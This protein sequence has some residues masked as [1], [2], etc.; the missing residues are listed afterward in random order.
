MGSGEQRIKS[1]NRCGW[2]RRLV[3]LAIKVTRHIPSHSIQFKSMLLD[4]LGVSD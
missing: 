1:W 4:N 3:S 2:E